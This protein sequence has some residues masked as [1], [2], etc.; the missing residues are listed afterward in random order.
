MSATYHRD[1]ARARVAYVMR[2]APDWAAFER[3][4]VLAYP[5]DKRS[6]PAWKAWVAAVSSAT[7][8]AVFRLPDAARRYE[9]GVAR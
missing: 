9:Q 1:V 8:L 7:A 6:G 5:F 3:G 2:H 4:L